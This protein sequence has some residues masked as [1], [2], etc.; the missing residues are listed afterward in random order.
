MSE[1]IDHS[2]AITI[3]SVGDCAHNITPEF[4]DYHFCN[5][6]HHCD[7]WFVIKKGSPL[8]QHV[9]EQAPTCHHRLLRDCKINARISPL[10]LMINQNVNYLLDRQ[11]QF[12]LSA[13]TFNIKKTSIFHFSSSQSKD[14]DSKFNSPSFSTWNFTKHSIKTDPGA[15]AVT[16][17]HHIY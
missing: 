7:L 2:F 16:S 5:R 11:S 13:S 10:H 15:S 9:N 6:L 4:C 8:R 14:F 17:L 3:K 12:I 1:K